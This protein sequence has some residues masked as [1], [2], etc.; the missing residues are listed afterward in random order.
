MRKEGRLSK[1]YEPVT[2]GKNIPMRMV[3]A[4]VKSLVMKGSAG[5]FILSVSIGSSP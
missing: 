3:N 4:V 5:L 1:E 2:D